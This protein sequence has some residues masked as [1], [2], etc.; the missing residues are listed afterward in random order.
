MMTSPLHLSMN[1]FELEYTQA[2]P[3]NM[4]QNV[5]KLKILAIGKSIYSVK[6]VVSFKRMAPKRVNTVTKK[7][8]VIVIGKV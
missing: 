6:A 5:I 8:E 7:K 4:E 1:D 2:E 3:Y